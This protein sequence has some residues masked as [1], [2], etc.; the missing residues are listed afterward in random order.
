MFLGVILLNMESDLSKKPWWNFLER[1]LKELL[2]QSYRLLSA[3]EKNKGE[4][5]DYSFVVF[6]SAKAYESF[7]KKLLLEKNFISRQE[8][9]GKHFR[10]GKA[11]NP[12]LPKKMQNESV[13][14]KLVETIGGE[15]LPLRLWNT[16][17]TSRNSTFHWFPNKKNVVSFEE[18][19]KRINLIV[20]SIDE[21]YEGIKPFQP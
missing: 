11:L 1:D 17:K 14:F 16:W 5:L 8:F 13:Y 15:E 20:E 19:R 4:F 3:F 10:I 9:E 7:L 2:E 18:S 12:Y 21:A 6:P